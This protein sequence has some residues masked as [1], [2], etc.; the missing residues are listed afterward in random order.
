[1]QK[2]LKFLIFIFVCVVII[3]VSLKHPQ[4]CF[5]QNCFDVEIANTDIRRAQGLMG[6]NSLDENKGML[7]VFN[8][9]DNYSFWMKNTLIPL[10]IIW[11]DKGGKV[12]FIK[13][14]A[15]P[16]TNDNCPYIIS[17][18][19]AKYVLEINAG[20]AG[21]INLKTGDNLDINL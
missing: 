18:T 6:I 16:C 15:Q 21:E 19:K 4:V 9:E 3:L 11:M 1:M 7:F 12:I 20:K 14:N 13:E 17:D 8:K 2:T 10:D 5:K